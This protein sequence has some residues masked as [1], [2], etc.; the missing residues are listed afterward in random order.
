MTHAT[1]IPLPLLDGETFM[2]DNSGMEGFQTCP[3][4]GQ[5]SL[6]LRKR[7]A[8]D[9]AALKFGGI[10]HKVMEPRY[11]SGEEMFAQT[12][13]VEALMVAAAKREFHGIKGPNEG[14]WIQPPYIPPFD[15]YRNFDRMID[16]IQTYGQQYPFEPF[17]IVRLPDG[18]PFV[19]FPFSLPLGELDL[20]GPRDFLVQDMVHNSEGELIKRGTP[21]PKTIS[22]L[23]IMWMGRIDLVY[24]Y[25]NN[26]YIMDHKSS[27]MAT[28]MAEFEIA[29]QFYGYKWAVETILQRPVVGVTIN[30]IVVRKPSRTGTA[31]TCERKL[32]AFQEGLANEWRTDMLHI[33]SDFVMMVQRSYM[34]KHTAWCVGK[35]GTCQFH[36]VCSLDSREQREVMLESGE[37]EDN[38]WSPLK[39]GV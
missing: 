26:V 6:C 21:Y 18:R 11:R 39:E 15:E 12:P 5:Y 3:R 23:K 10:M 8:G 7:S 17:D 25:S 1:H 2:V 28:N 20:G 19:E 13:A 27:S 35:F 30:R 33:V 9:K 34:P 14:E 22:V 37:F 31:F 16:L 38:T 32:I 24:T 29:H 4:A 36:K